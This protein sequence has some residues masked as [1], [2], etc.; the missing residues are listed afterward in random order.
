MDQLGYNYEDIY[1]LSMISNTGV[2]S[3]KSALEAARNY[4]GGGG[5]FSAGGGGFGSFGGGGG[6]GGFR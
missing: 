3:A 2:A 1:F 5:G 6:G 4:S